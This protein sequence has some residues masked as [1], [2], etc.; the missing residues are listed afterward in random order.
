[1]DPEVMTPLIVWATR[2]E[3]ARLPLND[4]V[5]KHARE[6]LAYVNELESHLDENWSDEVTIQA[7][8]R[9]PIDD[10]KLGYVRRRVT[11]DQITN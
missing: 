1:M 5:K 9:S 11:R 10:V 6:L 4:T 2:I 3:H 8:V 7:E